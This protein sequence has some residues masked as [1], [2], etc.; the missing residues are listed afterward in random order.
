MDVTFGDYLRAIITADH[1]MV[2][3]DRRHYRLAFL[4]AFRRRG[5]YPEGI[6]T[7][8]EE[9]LR[10]RDEWDG[11]KPATHRVLK[12]VVGEFLRDYRG[13]V[14]Y[15]TDRET[16]YNITHDFITG[17]GNHQGLHQRLWNQLDNIA[18]FGPGSEFE[19]LTGVVLNSD[20]KSL[21]V[22]ESTMLLGSRPSRS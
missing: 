13:V 4:D 15:E 9:N 5:I 8:S 22:Q 19:A 3:E 20:W 16:I 21:G 7:L 18:G 10:Y 2:T 11:L 17:R 12:D 6:R 14:M 1:E